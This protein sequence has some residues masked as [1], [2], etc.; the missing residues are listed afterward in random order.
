MNQI[1]QEFDQ[2]DAKAAELARFAFLENGVRTRKRVNH[3]KRGQKTGS[4]T[5]NLQ[6]T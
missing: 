6:T 5:E 2:R 4:G 3:G 1:D